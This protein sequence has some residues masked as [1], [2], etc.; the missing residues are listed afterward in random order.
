[1]RN[2]YATLTRHAWLQPDVW[3]SLQERQRT[4]ARLFVELGWLDLSHRQAL[5]LGCGAGGNLLELLRMGFMPS[6]LKGIE[7]DEH[8]H[9]HAREVLPSSLHLI[10]G[11]ALGDEAQ[12]VIAPLSQ[13]LVLQA[14]VF[15][16]ILDGALQKHL[17]DAMWRWVRPGGGMTSQSITR[18]TSRCVA[19]RWSAC[20]NSSHRRTCMCVPLPWLHRWR[21]GLAAETR[22]SIT[23]LMLCHG[24]A[25]TC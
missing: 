19:F 13:D 25:P 14:T 24:C 4:M 9:A 10:Y 6:H 21:A 22:L 23:S 12:R 5:E 2:P 20:G 16:S 11:D 3:Q 7:I 8:R 18:T 15:S 1:M 17:A